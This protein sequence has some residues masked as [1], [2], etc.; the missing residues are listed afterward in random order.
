MERGDSFGEQALYENATRGA[1]VIALEDD[2]RICA[3][4]RD[5]IQQVLGDKVKVIMITNV[6]RWA[7]E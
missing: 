2:V 5:T 3:L 7:I 4:G 6:M 1:S